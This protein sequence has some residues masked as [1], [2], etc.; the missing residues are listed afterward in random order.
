MRRRKFFGVIGGAAAWPL[1]ARGQLQSVRRI[2]LISAVSESDPEEMPRRMAFQQ[3][4]ELL[5]ARGFR[6][7]FGTLGHDAS[8]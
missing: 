3:G 5:G 2:G 6:R 7:G 4:L 8:S 1:A